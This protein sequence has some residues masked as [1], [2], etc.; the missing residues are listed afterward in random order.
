MYFH[1]TISNVRHAEAYFF[2]PVFIDASLEWPSSRADY[3][4]S[5]TYTIRYTSVTILFPF[6]N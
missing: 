4:T 2:I 1:P 3:F 5:I 6:F